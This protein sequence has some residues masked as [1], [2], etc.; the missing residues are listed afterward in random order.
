ME[1]VGNELC[2]IAPSASGSKLKSRSLVFNLRRSGSA[3]PISP[4]PRS[5]YP[6]P[7]T[8]SILRLAAGRLLHLLPQP[9]DEDVDDLKFRLVH[10]A[11][12]VVQE[13]LFRYRSAFMNSEQLKHLQF[14]ARQTHPLSIDVVSLERPANDRWQCAFCRAGIA[15]VN[16]L[17]RWRGGYL[18]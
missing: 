2:R 10:A 8:V 9:A 17:V 3:D 7:H 13:H 12:K 11:V 18:N 15:D 14:F 6:R 16:C 4:A 5:L 1:R